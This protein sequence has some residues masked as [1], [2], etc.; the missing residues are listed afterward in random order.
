M[1]DA[2]ERREVSSGGVFHTDMPTFTLFHTGAQYFNL[3][4]CCYQLQQYSNTVFPNRGASGHFSL[5]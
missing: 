4:V 3:G 5:E 2:A 1:T